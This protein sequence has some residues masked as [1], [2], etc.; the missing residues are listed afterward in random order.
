MTG[1]PFKPRALGEIAIRC[2][3]MD[4]MI[5]FY[6]DV[7]GLEPM[8]RGRFDGIQFFR[9]AESYGGHTAVMALFHQ[10]V[11]RPGIHPTETPPETGAKSSLHHL[12]LSLGFDEQTRAIAWFD[13]Q[14]IPYRIERFGWVGW[15][16]V[17]LRDPEGNTI[18]LVAY[19]A[20]MRD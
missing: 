14:Q 16:G 9:I 18:E 3:D 13:V 4:A 7:V 19:D 8:P 1:R 20:S 2:T 12:A 5:A 11:C 15:R 6:R 17:F 10:S